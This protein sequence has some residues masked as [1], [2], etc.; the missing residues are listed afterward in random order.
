MVLCSQ[1]DLIKKKKDRL[2]QVAYV[3]EGEAGLRGAD[4]RGGDQA[5][6]VR[7]ERVLP[8]VRLSLFRRAHQH[9]AWRCSF[10]SSTKKKGA[11]AKLAD[12]KT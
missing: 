7:R 6:E 12:H 9:V 5:L 10:S 1:I 11:I 4:V 8:D 2:M 3:R